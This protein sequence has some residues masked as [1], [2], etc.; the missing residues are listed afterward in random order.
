M[1]ELEL[2]KKDWV[3]S[4]ASFEQKSATQLYPMLQTNSSSI[5]KTL[6]YISI[7]E[8]IFWIIVNALPFLMSDTYKAEYQ[9]LYSK[10]SVIIFS[11][12]SY[13]IILVFVYLLFKSYKSISI[14]DNARKLMKSII[15]TRKVVKY[16]VLYN[17]VMA[18]CSMLF[19]FYYSSKKEPE[20]AELVGKLDTSGKIGMIVAFFFITLAFVGL[21]WLFYRLIY[22][23]LL[24][25]LNA[26]YTEL[27]RMEV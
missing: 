11:V 10:S 15:K 9:E 27:K 4:D 13:I 18:A 22:G 19:G 6:F 16:Y 14:T 3:K 21:I 2:L 17:L 23:I 7:A 20:F 1:D 25:R 8:L 24:R 26:N 5:V 12:L